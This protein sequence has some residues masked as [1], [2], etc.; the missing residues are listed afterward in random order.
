MTSRFIPRDDKSII[1]GH[2]ALFVSDNQ[3]IQSA[4][5]LEHPNKRRAQPLSTSLRI[6]YSLFIQL[7][8]AGLDLFPRRFGR[9]V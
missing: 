1:H 3:I 7:L 8:H 6:S 9:H 4:K 2:V 5:S